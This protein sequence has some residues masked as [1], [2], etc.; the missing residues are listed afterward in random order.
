VI[1]TGTPSG[2]GPLAPGD[3]VEVSSDGLGTLRNPV[4]A[5]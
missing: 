4:V 1:A 5:A 2:I 3:V